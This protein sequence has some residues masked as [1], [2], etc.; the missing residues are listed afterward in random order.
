MFT[1]VMVPLDGS[2]FAEHALPVAVH[3]ARSTGAGLLLTLVHVRHAPT[4]TDRLL[5]AEAEQWE[6]TQRQR[7]GEY[8]AQT[9]ARLLAEHGMTVRTTLLDGD[10]ARSLE[11]AVRAEHVDLVVITTH[12]RTGME[13]AWLGS[14]TD[15]LLRDLE[16]PVLVIRPTDPDKMAIRDPDA[17]YGNI[18]VA[19]D[20][21]ERAE[22]AIEPALALA[23]PDARVVLM[24][25]AAAPSAVTSP[26]IPHAARLT[27][28]ELEERKAEVDDYLHGLLGRYTG[29]GRDISA[30]TVVDYHPA[31]AILNFADEYNVDL[32]A[33]ST[34]GRGPVKRFVLGST[35]DK[36]VRAASVPLLVC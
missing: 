15:S 9:A 2:T 7:E 23:N 28:D 10:V 6:V 25:M 24:R 14:V 26:F 5:R 8:L 30:A 22:R 17:G 33:M 32:I 4:T 13:R 35:T 3:A 29:Q 12:G 18:V 16:V 34:H 20:G 27:H 31:H 36:V 19:L 1:R 21:S 11:Q